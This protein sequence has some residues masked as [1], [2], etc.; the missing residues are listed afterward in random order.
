MKKTEQELIIDR[1]KELKERRSRY[2]P[3]WKDIQNYVAITNDI[4][5]EF[6]DTKKESEQ[7][8]IFI[9]DPTAFLFYL[10]YYLAYGVFGY[11]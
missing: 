8:D 7:K 5:T 11:W 1:Y 10:I 6:E 9:N 2:V 4:N 3:K